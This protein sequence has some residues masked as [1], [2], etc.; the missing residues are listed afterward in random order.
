MHKQH[1]LVYLDGLFHTQFWPHSLF[2]INHA[3]VMYFGQ[4]F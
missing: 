2:V 3:N 4:C 1:I